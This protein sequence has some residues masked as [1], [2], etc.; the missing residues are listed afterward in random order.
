MEFINWH[1][2]TDASNHN[3]RDSIIK[4]EQ[5]IDVALELGHSGV[6]I[7][8]HALLSNHVKAIKYLKKLRKEISEKLEKEPHNVLLLQK[9]EQLDNFKLGLGCEIYLVNKNE[10]DY[11]REN[12]EYTKF[13]H[14]V[15]HPKNITGYRQLAKIS[16][17]G[18]ENSFYHRGMERTPVYKED[19]HKFI[20]DAKGNMI[21]TS[22]CLGSEFATYVLG[23]LDSK[24][25]GLPRK[26]EEYQ[27]KINGFLRQM[28]NLFGEDFYIEL[29]PN[30]GDE[31]IEYNTFALDLAKYY[32][33][34]AIIA[35]DAHYHR[36][37][38]KQ[39]H[40]D[41]L[42]S[43]N[44]ERE[45]EDFYS[46]T[47]MMSVEEIREYFEYISEEDFEW[48][49][50]N[51]IEI[52]S[53]I[54]EIDL[55]KPTQVPD[56][57]IEYDEQWQ[58]KFQHIKSLC[59]NYP[60]I[61]KYLHSEHLIDRIIL[62]QIEKGMAHLGQDY[63]NLNLDRINKELESMWFVSEG[64][65]ERL[66]S[67]YVLTK[68]IVDL[69]WTISLVGVSR[70]S[71]GAFYISY[72]LGICQINPI[73]HDLP[74]WRHLDK[75]KIELADIDI[76]SESAQR[77]NILELVKQKYGHRKVLSI[78]TFK[79]EG[80]ASAIQTICRGMGI[81]INDAKYLSSIVPR[82]GVNMK[83]ISYCLEHYG[84]DEKCT[85]FINELKVIDEI[86]NGFIENIQ[87][88]E[89]LICGKS[90]H[91]SGV[92]IF[93][94]DYTEV[95]ALMKTPSGLPITQ[96]DML[97]SDYQSGLKLDFLT[98]ESLDRIRKCMDLLLQDG[99]MEWQ[100]S[101][102]KTYNKYLHPD[103]I[104]TTDK[105]MFKALREGKVLDAF[106]YDSVAG[107]ETIS[108]IQPDNFRELMD[109]N[110]LM[111]L[112]PKDV[113]LPINVYVRHKQDINIWFEDMRNFGLVDQEMEVLKKH[114]MKSYGVAPT[115]E[116]IMRL[117][118]DENISGFD[119]VLANKLRKAVAKAYARHMADEVHE[120]MISK[121]KELGNREIFINYV[122]E[123]FVVP[124][125]KYSFSDPHLA[126]YT[127]I[128]M[129]ELNLATKYP[130]LYWKVACL[131]V[132]AGNI[133]EE[134]NK[135]TD[136]G[137]IAKAIAGMDKGFVIP[138]DINKA[139]MEFLPLKELNKAI[140]SL[141]AVN[142]IGEDVARAI[143][144]NR[145][146]NSFED[147]MTKCVDTK[148]VTTSKVYTLIKAGCFDSLESNREKL[149]ADFVIKT[150]EEK[151]RLTTAN[152]P[153]ILEY[154]I[155]PKEY[156][157]YSLLYQFRKM[158]F[159]KSNLVESINKSAGLYEIPSN[160]LDYYHQNYHGVFESAFEVSS[161]GL[162]CL[163][164]KLF[165]KIYK[166]LIEP[167]TEWLVTEDAINAFNNKTRAL[168]WDKNCS[169][170]REKWEM[171]SI[172]FYT[173]KHE[174]DLIPLNNEYDVKN[175]CDLPKE[176]V[177]VSNRKWRGRDI[178]E[179]R[180]DLIAGTVVEKNKNK[181]IVTIATPSGDVVDIKMDK[182]RFSYY[183]RATDNDKSWLTRGNKLMIVGY[184]KG[185]TFYPKVYRNN[186]YQHSIMKIEGLNYNT[187]RIV[188]KDEK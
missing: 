125:L 117:S 48:L 49:I 120:L 44:A 20:N 18:W 17:Q 100:G 73:E 99:E 46:S 55:F 27:F 5:M 186:Y 8:D 170:S 141:N 121:G 60:Y 9:K 35:T 114:L 22:A 184:R 91:A 149:M 13:Y 85:K 40:T 118:M 127:L 62:Q 96:Y 102:R 135:G 166:T 65:G 58:G 86:H 81:D 31:Q 182:G 128:L 90:S 97:D 1:G 175:F 146:Y 178:Q 71:A 72:L 54:E 57:T 43:Q 16:S 42:R 163:N 108:K 6:G 4:T 47:Y 150:A 148:I 145:P 129:Q 78:A 158:V 136:Y 119:L 66:S 25:L 75:S 98:I 94:D 95:N 105:N 112:N 165:D 56:A 59:I 130:D 93:K 172:C 28:V 76:D 24:K 67:Y 123:R 101:L 137:A 70:G 51:T 64:L 15:M 107:V 11:A 82:E 106:Q 36:P 74:E 111:R 151:T 69:I 89:G 154:G 87:R 169:G 63:N 83:S 147:F 34:K 79:T 29:Q 142:G 39:T 179:Y 164:N 162:Q 3:N 41:F 156:E 140:Y 133:S 113:E 144:E 126:G 2:H 152:I 139:G 109:G 157:V 19:L 33:I 173:D 160:V 84:Q 181:A 134:V 177:V 122:W 61:D 143:I 110:A 171:E 180:V 188:I 104:D 21:V 26:M 115:Q 45:T 88:V 183:D 12:N 185:E 124:Q 116:S 52:G 103:V 30:F 68:E 168:I 7:T 23:F 131:S 10:I 77:A 187:G 37:E 50:N 159:S 174:L 38:T 153:K 161:N 138:P 132:Q 53:K 155:L 14:L 92:Y 167:L 176:P 80:T 32:G